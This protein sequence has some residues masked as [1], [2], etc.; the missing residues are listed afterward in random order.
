[1]LKSH[2]RLQSGRPQ[3]RLPVVSLLLPG[4]CC[5]LS[6]LCLHVSNVTG[7]LTVGCR[8]GLCRGWDLSATPYHMRLALWTHDS[9]HNFAAGVCPAAHVAHTGS[10]QLGVAIKSSAAWS[11]AAPWLPWLQPACCCAHGCAEL[12]LQSLFVYTPWSEAS[13]A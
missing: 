3:G 11:A 9:A 7:A 8:R 5:I 1:M 4:L 2:R 10:W 6:F 12:K 13:L